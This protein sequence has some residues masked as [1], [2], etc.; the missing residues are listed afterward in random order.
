MDTCAAADCVLRMNDDRPSSTESE[1]RLLEHWEAAVSVCRVGCE[2]RKRTLRAT[3]TR[4]LVTA[5]RPRNSPDKL[6]YTHVIFLINDKF[7][8]KTLLVVKGLDQIIKL[9]NRD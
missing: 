1:W 4:A 8:Q 7:L 5:A 2:L 6:L 9:N 3:E